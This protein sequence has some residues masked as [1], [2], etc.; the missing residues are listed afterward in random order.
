MNLVNAI[1]G[2]G[3]LGMPFAFKSCGLVLGI[4]TL[5][6]CLSMS[7][8]SLLCLLQLGHSNGVR[9]YEDLAHLAFGNAGTYAINVSVVLLNIG[10][11]IAYANIFVDT[12]LWLGEGWL[13]ADFA[14]AK[15]TLLA[16][17]VLLG[18]L[19]VGLSVTS[20][21]HMASL[22]FFAVSV[23]SVFCVYMTFRGLESCLFSQQQEQEQQE[24]VL[25]EPRGLVVAFPI[26][27]YSFT[28]HCVIFPVYANMKHG[29][30]GNITRVMESALM[31]V[32]TIYIVVGSSA[33]L[34]F[35]GLIQGDVL[36]NLGGQEENSATASADDLLKFFYGLTSLATVPILL[37]PIKACVFSMPFVKKRI[38]ATNTHTAT[39]TTTT[40]SKNNYYNGNNSGSSRVALVM[41]KRGKLHMVIATCTLVVA[42]VCAT[43]IPHI[44]SVFRLTGGSTCVTLGCIL[45]SLIYLRLYSTLKVERGGGGENAN[46]K[47]VIPKT[48]LY[49][50]AIFGIISG[51]ICTHAALMDV[52][53]DPS[54]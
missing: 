32:C 10:V 24:L 23:Y 34:M 54:P 15:N 40:T 43:M 47:K 11:I 9:S 16:L 45:P 18:M 33:Y 3:M 6:L 14:E 19:P 48:T 2:G 25:W 41:N 36:T 31:I 29:S 38:I 8:V 22:A 26:M 20:G 51:V 5:L 44:E 28:P 42:L 35:R 13:F 4:S 12:V 37:V 21:K 17:T 49:A 1:V 50:L 53:K 30:L 46:S 39:T 52:E 27:L 7:R